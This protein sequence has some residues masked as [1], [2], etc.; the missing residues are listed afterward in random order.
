METTC[1]GRNPCVDLFAHVGLGLREQRIAEH[2][3]GFVAFLRIGVF[4]EI[5]FEFRLRGFVVL[6]R[7]RAIGL[8]EAGRSEQG[9]FGKFLR[10]RSQHFTRF[11][12]FFGKS[13]SRA[14]PVVRWLRQFVVR[15]LFAEYRQSGRRLLVAFG[16]ELREA[17]HEKSARGLLG[18]GE[19]LAQSGK[20]RDRFV[21]LVGALL[22]RAAQVE[23]EG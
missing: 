9:A 12:E 22:C 14:A 5:R 23:D 11:G 19:F 18:L 10:V 15:M 20:R 1:F 2:E 21:E 4:C 6:H 13:Q 16:E 8:T 7:L 17:F 3:T